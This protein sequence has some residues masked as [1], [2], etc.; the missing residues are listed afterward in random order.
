M[1]PHRPDQ[2]DYTCRRAVRGLRL[3]LSGA[4]AVGWLVLP[5]T[6]LPACELPAK[7]GTERLLRFRLDPHESTVR[8]DADA[9]LHTFSGTAGTLFGRIRLPGNVPSADAEAC[10]QI[11]AASLTTGI[12]LRDARMRK[13]H[14]ETDHFPTILFTLSGLE[15][16]ELLDA[17]WFTATL[18]GVLTLHGVTSPLKVAVKARLSSTLLEV[19]GEVPLQLSGFQISIPSFLFVAMKDEVIVRFKLKAV[20][21]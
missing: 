14:L 11:D 6:V 16:I 20:R 15:R 5:G 2:A 8:F 21:E 12:D 1:V 3:L 18:R 4:I 17:D 13:S 19:E 9:R 10:V 7:P